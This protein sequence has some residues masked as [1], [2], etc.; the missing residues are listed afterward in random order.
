MPCAC[1]HDLPVQQAQVVDERSE[2][3]LRAVDRLQSPR[4]ERALQRGD[5]LA[6]ALQHAIETIELE[7]VRR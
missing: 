7:T 1:R 5:I 4:I 3:T 6:R 2:L